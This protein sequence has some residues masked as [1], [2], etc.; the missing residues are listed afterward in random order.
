MHLNSRLE[1]M[2]R[3][4]LSFGILLL[5]VDDMKNINEVYG[6]VT[7]DKVLKMISKTLASNIRFFEVAGRWKGEQFLV[8]LLNLDN[9]K[10][11]LVANKLRLL[12]AQ[13]YLKDM[14]ASIKTTVSI[15]GTLAKFNDSAAGLIERAEKY[16]KHSKW[17]GKDKVTLKIE[18]K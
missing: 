17:L 12:I 4:G 14:D 8:V 11:D 18:N 10:L 9:E 3:Y 7:G 2:K 6:T 1:E 13:S 16:V 5:D 15:G